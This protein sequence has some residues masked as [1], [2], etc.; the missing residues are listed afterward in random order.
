MCQIYHSGCLC[1]IISGCGKCT[2]R[3]DLTLYLYYMYNVYYT[4]AYNMCMYSFKCCESPHEPVLC[5]YLRRWRRK[6]D[7]DSETSNWIHVNTKVPSTPLHWHTLTLI[8]LS[9]H[10]RPLFRSVPSAGLPLRR[11]E[12]VIIWCAPHVAVNTAGCAW[13]HGSH[14]APAGEKAIPLRM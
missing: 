7:D 12:G 13:V 1:Y 6:C 8:T 14:R 11:M 9:T 5:E 4:C 10:L 3:D 2:A